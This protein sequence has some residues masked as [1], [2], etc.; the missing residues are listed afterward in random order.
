MTRFVLIVQH[1]IGMV[2]AEPHPT[3]FVT[4]ARVGH[5]MKPQYVAVERKGLSH[6]ENLYQRR[7]PI[8]VYPHTSPLLRTATEHLNNKVAESRRSDI[9]IGTVPSF[10]VIGGLKEARI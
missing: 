7:H 3:G 4:V 2:E 6:I 10:S 1:Q 9:D 8:D 5:E